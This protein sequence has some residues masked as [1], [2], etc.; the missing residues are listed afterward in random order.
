MLLVIILGFIILSIM[1]FSWIIDFYE[2]DFTLEFLNPIRNYD[3]WDN[4]NWFGVII[5]T[6]IMNVLFPLYSV[7][8]WFW[9]LCT[10]GRR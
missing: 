8:Y 4:M 5:F 9:K 1:E 7:C 3:T 6:I 10:V 2:G